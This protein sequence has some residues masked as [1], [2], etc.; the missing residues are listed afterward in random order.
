MRPLVLALLVATSVPV[1]GADPPVRTDRY[2]DPLPTGAITRFG[3]LRN[4]APITGFGIEKDGT[5]VTVG[6]GVDV[7]R[8]H[9]TDNQTD[10]VSTDGKTMFGLSGSVT[11]GDL[12]LITTWDTATTKL[13]GA[14]QL[15]VG[16][17]KH[18]RFR[19][20]HMMRFTP[21]GTKLIT[22]HLDTTALVWV[23]PERPAK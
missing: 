19:F 8:W 13:L 4:R 7:C 23:V 16:D 15:P 2:G 1:L 14:Q 18:A 3:T 21:D 17:W 20:T 12:G 10:R 5:V 11:G 6:P 9:A 22:G